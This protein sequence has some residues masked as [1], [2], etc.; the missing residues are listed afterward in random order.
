MKGFDNFSALLT[1]SID[2]C[3]INV[4]R[5]NPT[6]R[7]YPFVELTTGSDLNR[8][9]PHCFSLFFRGSSLEIP[10]VQSLLGEKIIIVLKTRQKETT[11]HPTANQTSK[12][13]DI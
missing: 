1:Q 6:Q 2:L 9:V 12:Q 13:G 10:I 7:S 3:P 11:P 5:T 4:L 8:D